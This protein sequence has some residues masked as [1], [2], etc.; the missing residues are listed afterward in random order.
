MHKSTVIES[1]AHAHLK[2]RVEHLVHKMLKSLRQV[3]PASASSG[4]EH[5]SSRRSCVKSSSSHCTSLQVLSSSLD[6][7]S[8]ML[9]ALLTCS[10]HG[11]VL[12]RSS[13]EANQSSRRPHWVDGI[14]VAM[15]ADLAASLSTKHT[16][17][18]PPRRLLHLL[19]AAMTARPQELDRATVLK[20]PDLIKQVFAKAEAK[21]PNW[22]A[23]VC[24]EHGTDATG[25]LCTVLKRCVGE[26]EPRVLSSCRD[27]PGRGA[28][29]PNLNSSIRRT[30]NELRAVR[31]DL[32]VL[33]T[34]SPVGWS[35][36]K[37]QSAAQ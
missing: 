21:A 7:P 26:E 13:H 6:G 22:F 17:S 19:S 2:T 18:E 4:A 31:Q 28:Y 30:S 12:C 35:F 16:I 14:L 10:N 8:E 25:K 29:N 11:K 37:L 23:I 3:P 5:C 27:Y 32:H 36:H 33:V 1:H 34:A 15:K 20:E 24:H 9:A